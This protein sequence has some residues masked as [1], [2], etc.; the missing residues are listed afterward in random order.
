MYISPGWS[1]M[2]PTLPI[3]S[4]PYSLLPAAYQSRAIDNERGTSY[5]NA[6]NIASE[7][8]IDRERES[9]P[10]VHCPTISHERA[11]VSETCRYDR[12]PRLSGVLFP[13]KKLRGEKNRIL[14][15]NLIQPCKKG[16]QCLL[17]V[18]KAEASVQVRLRSN[19]RS[20]HRAVPPDC[21][22]SF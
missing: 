20:P 11:R 6:I 5:G 21:C 3:P 17:R 19:Q 2:V 9:T 10:T 8:E 7:R 22:L 4:C 14:P 13:K 16:I 1:P 18:R 12:L 15:K